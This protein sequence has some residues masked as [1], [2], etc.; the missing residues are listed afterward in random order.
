MVRTGLPT[1]RCWPA[2]RSPLAKEL[3]SGR[4]SLT[5]RSQGRAPSGRSCA[6]PAAD[7][8]LG[9][10]PRSHR[11]SCEP[12]SRGW[13]HG[14]H[15]ELAGQA[16]DVRQVRGPAREEVQDHREPAAG[17]RDSGA[18]AGGILGET[19]DGGA[20][21]EERPE[22]EAFI[23]AGALLER[24]KMRDQL[25]RRMALVAG[26]DEE[27]IEQV[28]IRKRHDRSEH[29]HGVGVSRPFSLPARP[30]AERRRG[31]RQSVCRATT[32]QPADA[33]CRATI[34]RGRRFRAP[35]EDEAA[36]ASRNPG[37]ERAR[38]ENKSRALFHPA[39]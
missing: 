24:G 37:P 23:E 10:A 26:Q 9:A 19:K 7:P 4:A 18:G 20:V 32:G 17:G 35:R 33:L 31:D 2:A 36:C 16:A 39:E 12:P 30:L 28:L 38:V 8:A 29:V 5:R 11:A 14:F 27:P 15:G 1:R 34:D 21:V 13:P 3:T 22:A 6:G 25:D